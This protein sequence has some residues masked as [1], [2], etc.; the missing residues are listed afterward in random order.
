MKFLKIVLSFSLLLIGAVVAVA[1]DNVL[2]GVASVPATTYAFQRVTGLSLFDSHTAA[3]LTLAAIPRTAQ[4]VPNPGGNNKLYLIGTDQIT[5]E[6]PRKDLIVSGEL[7][8]APT[9]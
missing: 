7:A 1:T 5:G 8:T 4:G 9:L 3:Y 6:W 2:L